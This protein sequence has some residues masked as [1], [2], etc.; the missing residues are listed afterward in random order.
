MI[1]TKRADILFGAFALAMILV[2]SG[3]REVWQGLHHVIPPDK[4]ELDIESSASVAAQLELTVALAEQGKL[5]RN[6]FRSMS[7]HLNEDLA[8]QIA[9]YAHLSPA[10]GAVS[11]FADYKSRLLDLEAVSHALASPEFD[12]SQADASRQQLAQLHATLNALAGQL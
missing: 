9:D 11:E 8:E 1:Q 10:P 12:F 7:E 6:Y 2:I 4:L 3:Y 5:T